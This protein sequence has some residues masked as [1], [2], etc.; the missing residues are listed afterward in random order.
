LRVIKNQ[1]GKKDTKLSFLFIKIEVEVAYSLL[2]ELKRNIFTVKNDYSDFI[3]QDDMMKKAN[4]YNYSVGIYENRVIAHKSGSFEF[5]S[6]LKNTDIPKPGKGLVREKNGFSALYYNDDLNSK[7]VIVARQSNTLYLFTT[8]FAYI[9]LVYFITM[10]TYILGNIIA[11]SNLNYTRFVN[12][13][14]INLRLRIHLAIIF[15]SLISF[16]AIGI[17]ISNFIIDRMVDKNRNQ[18]INYSQ[19]L[20]EDI[21]RYLTKNG[22]DNVNKL[23]EIFQKP[24]HNAEFINLAEKFKTNINLFNPLNGNLILAQI[25]ISSIMVC[26]HPN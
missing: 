5:P 23:Y 20:Q 26:W 14:N 24:E 22:V 12:L 25:I 15:L 19:S 16:T 3:Y 17:T 21:M 13:L 4:D 8:L 2:I 18:I 11:R 7:F 1:P 6:V 10:T 9:F